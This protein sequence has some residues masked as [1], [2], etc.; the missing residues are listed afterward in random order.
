MLRWKGPQEAAGIQKSK[1][2][3][4]NL[5]RLRS[6]FFIAQTCLLKHP[7]WGS[8]IPVTAILPELLV[9]EGALAIIQFGWGEAP[10]VESPFF[11]EVQAL[12]PRPPPVLL[13][14]G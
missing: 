7:L 11:S 2:T 4:G 13:P 1:G 8:A 6:P 9:D 12:L 3:Q 14:L 5:W 10:A